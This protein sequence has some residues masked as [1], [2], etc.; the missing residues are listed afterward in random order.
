MTITNRVSALTVLR[1][2]LLA[3]LGLALSWFGAHV[4]GAPGAAHPVIGALT[5]TEAAKLSSTELQ[6][7]IIETFVLEGAILD[8]IPLMEIEGN[9]FTYNIEG[10]LPGIEFRAVN[11]AYTESTGT[12]NQKTESLVILGGDADVDR[13]IQQ[14][15]SNVNDQRAEQDRMKIKAATYKFQGTFINGDTAVDANSFDGLKKRLSGAQVISAATNGSNVIGASNAE[16]YAFFDLVDQLIYATG[17]GGA[18]VLYM[19]SMILQKIKGAARRIGVGVSSNVDDF[20]RTIDMYGGVQM[21]D[22]GTNADG[23]LIIPQ[24]ETQGTSSLASSI[25]AV[26]WGQSPADQAVTGLTNGGVMVDDLGQIDAKP[27]LRT[28][29]EFYCGLAVFGTGA[30]RLKGVLNA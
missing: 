21:R 30:A 29:I 1:W 17:P 9:S 27:V 15:R 8:Q 19:N 28:R 25:Y 20:G 14:T 2:A 5:L 6:R 4:L 22:I 13:F 12:F 18:D 26:R 3:V 10:A 11:A 23:T 24:T 16:I 7:G